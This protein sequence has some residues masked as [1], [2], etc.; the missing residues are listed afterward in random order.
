MTSQSNSISGNVQSSLPIRFLR[1]PDVLAR[2][3]VS[4]V[5]LWRWENEG[6]FPKRRKIGLHAV[7]WVEDE[8]DNWCANRAAGVP[9]DRE[10]AR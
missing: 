5:T 8:V 4:A 7:A 3:G 10:G 1:G 6:R 9:L 2:V